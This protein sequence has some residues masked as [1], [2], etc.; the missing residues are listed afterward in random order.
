[1]QRDHGA[2]YSSYTSTSPGLYRDWGE[3]G[4]EGKRKRERKRQ[5]EREKRNIESKSKKGMFDR[6]KIEQ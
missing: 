6:E 1:M 2:C 3:G 4:G 5:R